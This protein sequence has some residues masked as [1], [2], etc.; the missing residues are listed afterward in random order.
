MGNAYAPAQISV[1]ASAWSRDGLGGA[2]E[3]GDGLVGLVAFFFGECDHGKAIP[4]FDVDQGGE[5]AVD[6]FDAGD[7]HGEDLRF[8]LWVQDRTGRHDGSTVG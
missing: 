7:G 6:V 1:R 4:D 3:V 8:R 5:E 2:V